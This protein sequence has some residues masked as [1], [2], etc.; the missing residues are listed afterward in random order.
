LWNYLHDILI[1][2]H[3]VEIYVQNEKEPHISSGVYSLLKD[4]WLRKPVYEKVE[5]DEE[6]ITK[7]VDSLM[8]QIDR[9]TGLMDERKYEEAFK[10][11][12]M[13]RTKIKKFRKAGLESAGEYS[14]ENLAFKRLRNNGYLTNL[15]DLKR[16]AYDRLM[17]LRENT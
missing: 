13:L 7:K 6:T 12:E 2:G 15:S 8:D 11:A 1:K 3:E 5:I 10:R 17:S 14:V 9:A 4:E 16:D